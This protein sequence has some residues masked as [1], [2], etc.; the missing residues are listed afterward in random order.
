MSE[1]ES[2][3]YD[4]SMSAGVGALPTKRQFKNKERIKSIEDSQST[5]FSKDNYSNTSEHNEN[6]HFISIRGRKGSDPVIKSK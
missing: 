2:D 3:H 5:Y 6:I 4:E 1:S